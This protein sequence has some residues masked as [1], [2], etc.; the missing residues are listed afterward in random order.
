MRV[1]GIGTLYVV[2][3]AYATKAF[4][5]PADCVSAPNATN[6]DAFDYFKFVAAAATLSACAGAYL[7]TRYLATIKSTIELHSEFHSESFTKAR[8]SADKSLKAWIEDAATNKKA[9][10]E[11]Y[12]TY[13]KCNLDDWLNI[14]RTL[15]FFERIAIL[16][17]SKLLHD[18]LCRKLFGRYLQHYQTQYFVKFEKSDGEWTSLVNILNYSWNDRPSGETSIVAFFVFTSLLGAYIMGD[19]EFTFNGWTRLAGWL[20]TPQV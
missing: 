14:S 18:S 15:H 3:I 4:G 20:K 13:S 8:V 2:L 11:L 5:T 17:K 7:Y 10:S 16:H 1:L 19:T 12:Q 6:I 9:L